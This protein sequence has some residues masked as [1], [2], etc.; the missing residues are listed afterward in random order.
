MRGVYNRIDWSN[1]RLNRAIAEA[2]AENRAASFSQP[3][4]TRPRRSGPSTGGYRYLLYPRF[5]ILRRR[6][7]RYYRRRSYY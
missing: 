3:P 5:R 6:R 4:R 7:T 2:E 1:S